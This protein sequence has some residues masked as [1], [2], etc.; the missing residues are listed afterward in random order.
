LECREVGRVGSLDQQIEP[1]VTAR[2]HDFRAAA[3]RQPA[4]RGLSQRRDQREERRLEYRT[5]REIHE[6]VTEAFAK[7]DDHR[8]LR[9]FRP[10][11]A[12]PH[13]PTRRRHDAQGRDRRRIDPGSAKRLAQRA[14]LYRAVVLGR[15]VLQRTSAAT[16]EMPTDG[17][18]PPRSIGEALHDFSFIAAAPRDA[19]LGA[20]TL[21]R[22]GERQ[23]HRLTAP[24][25]N[26]VA[27]RTQSVDRE[28]GEFAFGSS[29]RP[30][31]HRSETC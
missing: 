17:F 29:L 7:P 19:D 25:G 30:P 23:I 20:Y 15:Q 26:A 27:L 2:Q 8:R 4:V 9:I 1:A 18:H 5:F 21:A 24:F 31:L 3:R 16:A 13:P 28:F 11:Q 10:M 22:D 14:E 12:E 6:R